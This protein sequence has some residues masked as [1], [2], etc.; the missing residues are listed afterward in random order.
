MKKSLFKTIAVSGFAALAMSVH[1]DQGSSGKGMDMGGMKT[2]CMKNTENMN[3][4]NM[5]CMRNNKP[6]KAASMSDGEVKDVDKANKRITLKHGPIEN[7]HMGP[8]T[9]A[10]SVKDSALLSKVKAGD[11][12]KFRVQSGNNGVATV[13]SLTVQK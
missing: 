5:D 6:A 4:M 7:M 1:A 11:K 9:M 13:T 8:M 3:G 10:F 2:G 12:V